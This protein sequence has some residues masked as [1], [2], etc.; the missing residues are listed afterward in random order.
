MTSLRVDCDGTDG[1]TASQ[2]LMASLA[3][4]RELKDSLVL[5]RESLEAE[6]KVR[7][8]D[9]CERIAGVERGGTP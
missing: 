2:Q 7:F 6:H 3:T 8:Q 4:L 1:T 5:T 9:I